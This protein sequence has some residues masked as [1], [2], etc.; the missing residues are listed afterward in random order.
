MRT[1]VAVIIALLAGLVTGMGLIWFRTSGQLAEV[2]GERN[3]EAA[4][5]S[6]VQAALTAE[7]DRAEDLARQKADC[8]EQLAALE[9]R[10]AQLGA[11]QTAPVADERGAA[12]E[13]MDETGKAA[14]AAEPEPPA[15]EPG[16]EEDERN[17]WRDPERREQMR[18]NFRQGIN[19]F[20]TERMSQSQDPAEQDRLASLAEYSDYLFDLRSQIR[21]ADTQEA[22]EALEQEYETAV[23]EARRV[24]QE[25]QRS[26][27]ARV[28]ESYGITSS[29]Q[30]E[31]F[32]QSVRGLMDDPLMRS[33]RFMGGWR[34]GPGGPGMGMGMGMEPPP[35][36]F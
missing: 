31:A 34:G 11:A 16:R 18:E 2:H 32:V 15:G 13:N 27:I 29:Q 20:L 28:A 3:R 12:P 9:R 26:M 8:A 25:Q 4:A 6:D 21:N 22:R 10:I 19:T 35:P 14:D 33:T 7:K 5:I 24:A 17:P 1:T 36:P 30:Q 23:S